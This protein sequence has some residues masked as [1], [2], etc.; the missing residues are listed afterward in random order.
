MKLG[1]NFLLSILG[2]YTE[3]K[4]QQNYGQGSKMQAGLE[5]SVSI[6]VEIKDFF[7]CLFFSMAWSCR[8]RNT[9]YRT[10]DFPFRNKNKIQHP[11]RTTL[12]RLSAQR[13]QMSSDLLNDVFIAF[14]VW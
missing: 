8:I 1:G 10:A 7:I 11:Q 9:I 5:N 13:L 4:R 14:N 6:Q 3:T 12:R 2:N